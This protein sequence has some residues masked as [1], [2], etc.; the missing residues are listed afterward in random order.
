MYYYLV[1]SLKRR[2]ILELQDSFSRHPVYQKI[3]PFIQNKYSFSERPQF[4]IVVK[5]SSANKVQFDPS[6]FVGHIQSYVMQ[7][8]VEGQSVSPIEWV[9]EDLNCIRQQGGMPTAPG[10]YFVEVLTAPTNPG[11]EGTFV[12]D[13]LETA[14]DEPVLLMTLGTETEGQLQNE[15][16]AGTL[17]LYENRRIALTEGVDYDL[18][19]KGQIKFKRVFPRNTLITADFRVPKDS[20]GPIPFKW[21]TSN[22]TTLPGVV[23]AFGKRAAVG[24][25]TAVVVYD[26]RVDAAQAFGGKFEV[27][28]D[29]DVLARD[30]IQREEI[31]DLVNMYLWSEKKSQLEFEGIEVVDIS[32]GGEG[33]EPIDETGQDFQYTSSVSVQLRA[34]WEVHYPLPLT[35]SRVALVA[36]KPIDNGAFLNTFPVFAGRNNNFERIG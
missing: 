1:G 14:S 5:G 20:I 2:L 25:K 26:S 31:A 28:F 12:I 15:P 21:N 7:A 34:D 33:E 4:G 35:I 36:V 22:S 19:P 24:Q 29:L 13:P 6:N 10:I 17:R 23:M 3:V 8:R 32:L 16:L 30:P 11:E 9:R 27:S 18:L